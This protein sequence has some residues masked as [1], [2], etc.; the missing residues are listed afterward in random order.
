MN[1]AAVI[2]LPS[3]LSEMYPAKTPPTTPPTSKSVDKFPDVSSDRYSPPITTSRI[4]QTIRA[5]T[6]EVK[7]RRDDE[8]HT[9]VADI[10]RK[11][12]EESV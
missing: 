3:S 7:G 6:L 12:V 9:V 1:P 2:A 10:E 4:I 11:P 5:T 8:K